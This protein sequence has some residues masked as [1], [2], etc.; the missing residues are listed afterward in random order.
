MEK[1]IFESMAEQSVYD[2]FSLPQ[3]QDQS[4]TSF[5]ELDSLHKGLVTIAIIDIII[6]ILLKFV[7]GF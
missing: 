2:D 6:M 1:N 5:N 4:Q 3:K 7:F